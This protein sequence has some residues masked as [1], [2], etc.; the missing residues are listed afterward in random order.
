MKNLKMFLVLFS[1][2]FF[3]AGLQAQTTAKY[4]KNA[5][6]KCC[7]KAK[8]TSTADTKTCC[9]GVLGKLCKKI[10]PPGCCEG[11]KSVSKETTSNAPIV[12]LDGVEVAPDYS[13]G[14]VCCD[15]TAAKT[16]CKKSVKT[17]TK[18]ASAQP[19]AQQV[20]AVTTTKKACCKKGKTCSKTKAKASM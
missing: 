19:K 17:S 5:N 13:N 2:T 15:E 1:M 20:K 7:S 14:K 4:A 10:C 12:S 11:G 3:V 16:C 9:D 8:A 6:A 18:T